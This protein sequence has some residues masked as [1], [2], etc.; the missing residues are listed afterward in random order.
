MKRYELDQAINNNSITNA[1]MLFGE[2]HFLIDRYSKILSRVADAS[3]LSF[4]HDEYNFT[5]AKSHLSQS[6]LFGDRSVLVIKSE[7]KIPKKDLDTLIELCQKNRDNIFIYAYY[8]VD[9][10]TSATAFNKKSGSE[11]IRFFT[12]NEN[13]AKNILIQAAREMKLDLDPYSASHLLLAQ[14]S[15]IALAYNEL[16]KLSILNRAITPKDIDEL[17]YGLA[18]VSL[19]QLIKTI[20]NKKDFK[21]QLQQIIDH[22]EDE[23]RIITSISN[24]ITQLFLFHTYIKLHGISSSVAVL[25]YKLPPKLEETLAQFSIKFRLDSYEKALKLLLSTELSMKSKNIDKNSLLLSSLIKLQAI[26]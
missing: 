13:E 9:Y 8:G 15:D 25:G 24:Y 4:Y 5:S 6:S 11:N 2:S 19:D 20:L 10:R 18:Q 26:L 12:P 7:K 1:V 16:S 14:N 23:I 17:V 21:I 3:I 22:G